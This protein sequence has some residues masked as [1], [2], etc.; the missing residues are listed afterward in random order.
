MSSPNNNTKQTDTNSNYFQ[1]R[2]G[3]ISDETDW[4]SQ[5]NTSTTTA[6]NTNNTST[7]SAAA[8]W[9]ARDT[10]TSL[11]GNE[12]STIQ[13]SSGLTAIES[14]QLNTNSTSDTN[15]DF[16][17]SL[18]DIHTQILGPLLP[19]H[20]NDI[21]LNEEEL[22]KI[23]VQYVKKAF[24]A[25]AYSIVRGEERLLLAEEEGVK[26]SN[27]IDEQPTQ[28]AT[29]QQATTTSSTADTSSDSTSNSTY[30][31]PITLA[32]EAIRT[33]RISILNQISTSKV[34][35]PNFLK[36]DATIPHFHLPCAG[37]TA[38]KSS[39]PRGTPRGTP[40]SSP[41]QG[42]GGSGERKKK[43]SAKSTH[44]EEV[45]K[46]KANELIKANSAGAKKRTASEDDLMS[47]SKKQKLS[48]DTV[49]SSSTALKPT[50]KKAAVSSTTPATKKR[51]KSPASTT[52][53]SS[54][55]KPRKLKRSPLA[56]QVEENEK[57]ISNNPNISRTVL[58]AAAASVFQELHPNYKHDA[59]S[60]GTAAV[61]RVD[62]NK[63]VIVTPVHIEIAKIVSDAN[64]NDTSLPKKF[65]SPRADTN[66]TMDIVIHAAKQLSNRVLDSTRGVAR[67]SDQRRMFR[68]DC[69]LS[70]LQGSG[71]EISSAQGLSLVVPNPFMTSSGSST[72]V[73]NSLGSSVVPSNTAGTASPVRKLEDDPEWTDT[74]LPRLLDIMSKGAG[75]AVLHDMQ[76][77]NRTLRIANLLQNMANSP[78]CS[79]SSS[80]SSNYGPHLI[81]TSSG[82]DFDQFASAFGKLEDGIVDSVFKKGGSS[83]SA[84]GKDV[85]LRALSYQGSKAQRRQLRKHFGSLMPSSD[86]HFAPIG[87][88]PDSPFHV[89]LT[90]YSVLMEDY[91]HFCQIPFQA[92]VLD[93]G[94]GWLGCSHSDPAGKLGKTWCNGLW[95]N[96]DLAASQSGCSTPWDFSKDVAGGDE[97]KS[98]RNVTG[99]T[100]VER[101]GEGGGNKPPIGLTARH[102][103]LVASNIHA[104]YRGQ[105]YKAPVMGLLTFLAPQFAEAI[106]SE[107]EKSRI[108]SCKKSMTYFRSMLSRMIVI[109]SDGKYPTPC[110]PSDLTALSLQGLNAELPLS[111]LTN[112]VEEDEGLDELINSQ[113]ISQSRKFAVAWFRPFSSI[114]KEIS[115][116]SLD[117]ILNAVKVSNAKGFVCEEIVTTS[118]MTPAGA[119]GSIVGMSAFRPAIRC[120]RCFSSEQGL[121][122]HLA[123]FHSSPGKW[124]CRNCGGDCGSSQARLTHEKTCNRAPRRVSI[125]SPTEQSV[126]V[127]EQD[128]SSGSGKKKK[129]SAEGDESEEANLV[130]NYNGVWKLKHG[131][132]P[133]FK[134]FFVKVAG[135]PVLDVSSASVSKEI[136]LFSTAEEA[137]KKYDQVLTGG[138]RGNVDAGL[139]NESDLN[140]NLDGSRNIHNKYDANVYGKASKENGGYDPDLII[141]DLSI[142][143]I[144]NLPPHVKPLLRDPTFTPR[145]GGDSKRYV[146]AYR[147]VCRQQRKGSDRWQ[148]QIS[149]N[150]QNHYLG[151]FDSEWDAA[152]VYAWAHL[153]LYGEEATKKAALEGDK[154]AEEFAQGQSGSESSPS[155]T[156]KKMKVAID[157]NPSASSAFNPASKTKEGV[158]ASP[159][160]KGSSLRATASGGEYI[161]IHTRKKRPATQKEWSKLKTECAMMLSS[162]TKGTS[163]ALILATR[164]DIAKMDEKELLAN[165]QGYTSVKHHSIPKTFLP[166]GESM[167]L[168]P[169]LKALLIGLNSNDFG[170]E[171]Q[172]F[173]KTCQESLSLTQSEVGLTIKLTTEYGKDGPNKSF[174]ACMLSSS[175]TLG[176]ATGGQKNKFLPPSDALSNTAAP[177]VSSTSTLGMSIDGIDCDVGG[178]EGSCSELAAKIEYLPSKHG[179]FQF[180]ACNED[181]I[182]TLNGH[183]ISASTGP[184]PLCDRDVCSVGARVFVFIEQIA[185]SS[186]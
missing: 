32:M 183:R 8:S 34:K 142:I 141:P 45:F 134:K 24:D 96:A 77:T 94:M 178:P 67:R 148:S 23:D 98:Q 63:D 170:W 82:E 58:S 128:D 163:K 14:I 95:N 80:T 135:K 6:P 154:A 104:Q 42:G 123:S 36:K 124:L 29:S 118:S 114:R 182:V 28:P 66:K 99:S 140:Y 132:K 165:V 108:F 90:T 78:S 97:K 173:I 48:A 60:S 151:T 65:A 172:K 158:K 168:R 185:I 9:R 7:E 125:A 88:L 119:S 100:A 179:N 43:Q 64:L 31:P 47:S 13:S 143:D 75:H 41:V 26:E 130:A 53:S 105:T 101:V 79:S 102:R 180:M 113:K 20:S 156:K 133:P 3:L 137:A 161:P 15:N 160:G 69:A 52:K 5:N 121:K 112:I 33:Q 147:G 4:P 44:D 107:W 176:R 138:G 81:V 129:R 127:D 62:I 177:G 115:L 61:P 17:N 49:S 85:M 86:S 174:C 186:Q 167:S 131:I 162:G 1:W 120:G 40:R 139:V 57:L 126:Q 35:I 87:G 149:F 19:S 71:G 84:T 30:D 59:A 22:P 181:D 166:T 27:T 92:V 146:Y 56:K 93:E 50:P 11:L 46:T 145:T 109:Y 159:F 16:A 171:V 21:S 136:L 116:L 12:S 37:G 111:T 55:T 117:P 72:G 18:I 38:G 10:L 175:F 68:M 169:P 122:L 106:E 74:C 76:W 103:I 73:E 91:A 54:T 184:H 25:A 39:T 51:T 70:K 157:E 89:I 150:G 83:S 144:K 164:K 110:T 153:I 155:P 152:A 2:Q